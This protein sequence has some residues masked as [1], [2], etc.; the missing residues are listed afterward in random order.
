MEETIVSTY[1]HPDLD[2]VACMYAYSELLNKQGIRSNYYII[3]EPRPE[4]NI[5]CDMFHIQLAGRQQL[6]YSDKIVIVDNHNIKNFPHHSP[7]RIVEI[8]D[9]HTTK[10]GVIFP[11]HIKVQIDIIGA[12]ATIVAER[13]QKSKIPISRESAILLYYGIVSNSVNL[14]SDV[15]ST[16]DIAMTNWLATQFNEIS[17]EKI[18]ELF[19]KKSVIP[20]QELQYAMEL[21]NTWNYR[22]QKIAIGQLEL[23]NI[24]SFLSEKKEKIISIMQKEKNDRKLDYIFLNCIDIL[25]GFNIV[26]TIDQETEKFLKNN[27]GFSFFDGM[28]QTEKIILRKELIRKLILLDH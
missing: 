28:F 21:G 23:A 1:A 14:K 15:T 12:A 10:E 20:E 11:S 18:T 26:M 13:F 19:I 2:G 3:E 22:N 4:V 27:F 9:H 24:R 8:I 25:E 17:K 7:D 5:L 6:Q 16:R